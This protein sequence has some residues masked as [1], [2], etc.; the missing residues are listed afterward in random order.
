MH[1]CMPPAATC[2]QLALSPPTHS[3]RPFPHLGRNLLAVLEPQQLV[4]AVLLR[5]AG[6]G[7]SLSHPLHLSALLGRA[8][9]LVEHPRLASDMLV[10]GPQHGVVGRRVCA[11]SMAAAAHEPPHGVGFKAAA[12]L[13][14]RV[15]RR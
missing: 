14:S 3:S 13:K 10:V 2:Q 8:R 4:A 9:A 1:V 11:R 7:E 12:S 6:G 15:A 5:Q